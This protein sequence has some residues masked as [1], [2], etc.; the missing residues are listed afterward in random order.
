MTDF[1][2]KVTIDENVVKLMGRHEAELE[3][4]AVETAHYM[5]LELGDLLEI[6]L[7]FRGVSYK[8]ERIEGELQTLLGE[9]SPDKIEAK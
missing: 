1:Y 3:V 8:I 7:I 5:A 9:Y 4:P 2:Y 6:T